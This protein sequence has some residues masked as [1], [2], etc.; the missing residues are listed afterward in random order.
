[1]KNDFFYEETLL[2]LTGDLYMHF[3]M[4]K[5]KCEN[6]GHSFSEGEPI[7][8]GYSKYEKPI[9]VCREC[10]SISLE[11]LIT[12]FKAGDE[13]SASANRPEE[14][15]EDSIL[16]RYMDISK[17]LSLIGTRKLFF[18][19]IKN[20]Q[21]P[22]ESAYSD[23]K[24]KD[25]IKKFNHKL[26]E[27]SNY[28]KAFQKEGFDPA[29]FAYD[30]NDDDKKVMELVDVIMERT[31]QNIR[32]STYISCWHE[33]SFESDAMWKLYS[34]EGKNG[35]AIQ[36][37]YG[38]LKDS[39]IS[40]FKI[41]IGKVI[42]KDYSIEFTDDVEPFWYKRKAFE[43]ENEVR[44]V[45]KYATWDL[46]GINVDVNLDKLIE[47]I[48]ISPYAPKWF[49]EVVKNVTWKYELNKEVIYSMMTNKPYF[50]SR[51]PVWLPKKK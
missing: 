51:D 39:L 8:V 29:G 6:C 35:I 11:K 34:N 24:F 7:F 14:P 2:N 23:E 27:L 28:R 40:Q 46:D 44:A 16:W 37:T 5:D 20:L 43:F 9:C 45:I 26:M 30:E 49:Y 4:H 18:S 21:D 19:S 10:T 38:Q 22:F 42:Y 17:F 48:Y 47:K 33:N 41:E 3:L 12:G 50:L 25:F 31:A 36:T 1:M 15:K 32:R 13:D